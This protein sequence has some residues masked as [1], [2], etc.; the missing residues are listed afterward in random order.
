[1]IRRAAEWLAGVSGGQV[2]TAMMIVISTIVITANLWLAVWSA[3]IFTTWGQTILIQADNNTKSAGSIDRWK[4]NR[5]VLEA[6]RSI[7]CDIAKRLNVTEQA[8][9]RR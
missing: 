7:S 6:N 8:C 4:A 3:N 9:A 2:S 1:M 5:G